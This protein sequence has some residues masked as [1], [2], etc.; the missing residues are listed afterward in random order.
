MG[1]ERPTFSESWYRV[2]SLRP[3]L[4]ST[5]QIHRQYFRGQLWYVVQ[6]ESNNEF[7]RLNEP[8]Y[9]FVGMLDGHRT[10]ADVWGICNEELGDAAPTQGEAIQ[11][12]GQL[13]THNLLQAELPPDAEGMFRRYRTRAGREMRG[14]LAN[15]LFI[16]IP[17]VDPDR[18]L[19][20][21]VR[22][23]G[24]LFSWV[25]IVVWLV[26]VASGL[27]FLAGRGSRLVADASAVLNSD[28]LLLLYLSFAIIK[29]LHEFGHGFACKH[30]GRQNGSG[31]EV[32]AMGIMLLVFMPVPYVDASSSWAFRSKR[33]RI[34]VAAAGILVELAI[35]SL[36]AIVWASTSEG[37]VTHAIA[38]NIMFVAS[39]TT[40]LFNGNPLLRYDGYYVFSDILEIAN[41][42]QRSREYLYYVVKR[43]AWGLRQAR[44]PAHTPSERRWMISYG[45]ASTIYRLFVCVA[46]L[47]FVADKLFVVGAILAAAA[48]V[49]W[50]LAPLGRL[51]HY[52]A[53]SDELTR[54]RA[55]AVGSTLAVFVLCAIGLG[56]VP[57]P[58]RARA[59]GV[60]EPRRLAIVHV[61]TDG[62]VDRILPSGSF[63]GPQGPAL[64]A[65]SSPELK[66]HRAQLVAERSRLIAR[67][68]L[69]SDEEDVA[70]AQVCSEQ[71]D[72]LE[73]QIKQDDADIQ[74]LAIYAPFSGTWVAPDIDRARG[75]YLRRG[76]RIG[77]VGSLDD[78]IMRV[79]ASQDIA[80]LLFAEASRRVEIRAE[81]RPDTMLTGTIEQVLPA[82]Q[83]RLP[84]AALG[85]FAGGEVAV[86]ADDA[87][88]TRAIE[89]FFEVR[90]AP[91]RSVPL[92]SG[93]RIVARFDMG[94]KPLALQWWR[95]LSQLLQR[96]FRI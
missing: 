3:R 75:A 69:A 86:A 89:P 43:Y 32:H 35:A 5:T 62:F 44:S 93:Q 81:D 92:M 94:K 96:R 22:L 55:R 42:A 24:G 40:L 50:V 64:L 90:I 80:A 41:L 16:R 27:Y 19:D 39:V 23:F 18:F 48:I 68:R 31:G 76:D 71:I 59:K 83:E 88:G 84:S 82:G 6:D 4:R 45:V 52:L 38:Y 9:R 46:I 29:A 73:E 11:L 20:R 60:V 91:D 95:S 74:A 7:F 53:A 77:L 47:L 66:A 13:Y 85:Y 51:L 25:G 37:A 26:L 17:L 78:I 28:N 1:A 57:V 8:A 30:F 63:V 87:G 14:Y 36:A 2:A 10:V 56:V 21:W 61:A 15:L 33:Q 72:A 79:T 49:T 12:L 65:A 70:M 34:T 67:R 58:D 54:V